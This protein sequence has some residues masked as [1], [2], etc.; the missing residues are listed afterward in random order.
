MKRIL[1]NS[2]YV[3]SCVLLCVCVLSACIAN[4]RKAAAHRE[5]VEEI[6]AQLLDAGVVP[7]REQLERLDAR[8]ATV[9]SEPDNVLPQWAELPTAVA[10]AM[11]GVKTL[12]SHW[13]RGPFDR[14]ACLPVPGQAT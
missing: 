9:E 8:I 11:L 4:P 1:L 12:P 5:L 2:A 7:T 14:T 10:A 13:F 6:T 3:A